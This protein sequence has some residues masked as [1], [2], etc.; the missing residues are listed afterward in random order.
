[1]FRIYYLQQLLLSRGKGGKAEKEDWT[2]FS[3]LLESVIEV[4][5][6]NEKLRN[7]RAIL[8]HLKSGP[9]QFLLNKERIP[10]RIKYNSNKNI[11][12]N[13]IIYVHFFIHLAQICE[14]L[15]KV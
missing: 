2:E 11:R 12:L 8:V 1:M 6:L 9:I 3:T 7:N 5:Y 10:I 13:Y 15:Q 14:I 4:N